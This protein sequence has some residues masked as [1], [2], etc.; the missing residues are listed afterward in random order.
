MYRHK[1]KNHTN[2]NRTCLS[3]TLLTQSVNPQTTLAT[4]NTRYLLSAH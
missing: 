3:L 1:T 4:A 2:C